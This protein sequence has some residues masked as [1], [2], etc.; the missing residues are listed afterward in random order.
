M[1]VEIVSSQECFIFG[2]SVINLKPEKVIGTV[3]KLQIQGLIKKENTVII[4]AVHTCRSQ[5][6]NTFKNS[7]TL[8]AYNLSKIDLLRI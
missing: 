4:K 8:I 2:N 3:V 1:S 7:E 6:L 5:F